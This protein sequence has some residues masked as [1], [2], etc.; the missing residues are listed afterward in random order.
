MMFLFVCIFIFVFDKEWKNLELGV[1]GDMD[2][3]RKGK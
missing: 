1:Q 3:L 2:D